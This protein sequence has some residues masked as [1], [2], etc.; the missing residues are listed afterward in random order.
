MKIGFIGCGNMGSSMAKQLAQS[1][2]LFIYDRFPDKITLHKEFPQTKICT[3]LKE[4][5]EQ[6]ELILLGVK[7]NDLESVAVQL[8]KHSLQSRQIL[9]S[10]LAGTTVARLNEVLGIKKSNSAHHAQFSR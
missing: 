5:V 2:Q 10:M 7:P 8:K 3:D 4:V 6:A 1:H 9:V